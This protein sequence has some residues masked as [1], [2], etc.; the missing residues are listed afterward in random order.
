VVEPLR[1]LVEA[2][3]TTKKTS[4]RVVYVGPRCRSCGKG[5]LPIVLPSENYEDFERA[6][7]PPLQRWWAARE[8]RRERCPRCD[9][10]GLKN[11]KKCVGCRGGERAVPAFDVPVLVEA[12]FYR[13]KNLG[14]CVGYMTA[15]ADVLEA[16]GIVTNDRLI[17]GWPMPRDGGEPMR[18]DAERPRLELWVTPWVPPAIDP[19]SPQAALPGLLE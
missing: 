5:R 8:P 15:L 19:D 13:E 18:K 12:V 9:G 17:V 2:F 14:D 11:G 7:A 10:T 3:P 4:N 1:I 16:A 6:V